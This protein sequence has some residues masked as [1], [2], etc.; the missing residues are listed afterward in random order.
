MKLKKQR[1]INKVK[2]ANNT[3]QL[4]RFVSSLMAT[5]GLK[6]YEGPQ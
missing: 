4:S 1:D 3:A 5:F 2:I 6:C